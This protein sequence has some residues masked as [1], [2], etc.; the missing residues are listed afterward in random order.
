MI[1][2]DRNVFM[3]ML[4]AIHVSDGDFENDSFG[5][6]P[7][8]LGECEAEDIEDVGFTVFGIEI[9]VIAKYEIYPDDDYV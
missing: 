2:G 3:V 6:E 1:G 5:N 7:I 9:A 4:Y 8:T